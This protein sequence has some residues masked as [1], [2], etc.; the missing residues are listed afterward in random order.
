MKIL[1]IGYG[2]V[3]SVLV[4]LLM[5]EKGVEKIYCLDLK[6]F[7]K[8]K[9]SKVHF[10]VFNA[11]DKIKFIGYLNRVRPDVVINAA[12]PKFNL[13]IMESCLEANV[14]YMDAAS[15][16]DLDK[17]P[18]AKV[19]YKME[20]LDYHK[21]FKDNKILGLIE[22]GVAPGLDNMFAAQA[23]SELDETDY[24]KIR[25]VEDT[26]SKEIFFSWN[27]DWLLDEIGSKPIIYDKG[28]W[29]FVE[30]F[31]AEEEFEFPKPIGK[32]KTYY[33]CQD[34]VGSIP[35]YV[36]TKKLDVKIHDN[37]IEISKLLLAL[38]LV[39]SKPI[40]VDGVEVKPIRVLSKLLPDPV[41]GEE[42]KFPNSIFAFAVEAIGKKDGKKKAV[43]YSIVFPNQREI[44]KMNIG[45]NFISY[46]TA[47]SMKLFTMALDR[48]TERGVYPPEILNKKIREDIIKQLPKNHVKVYK[49][50]Y[51]PK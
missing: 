9:N 14:N 6:F 48:V 11:L 47:L 15:Y 10:E 17:D 22:A 34:E 23:A 31:G 28:K 24:I 19:P 32:R 1:I 21:Q 8:L 16:W 42:K 37:N 5:K 3:G 7:E 44:G 33:F 50:V 49:K 25:M 20:Q 18:N 4:K 29:S 41:P 45:A 35:D 26:G 12:I 13:N 40:N 39:S 2:A 30:S 38:G 36:K 51:T 43:R 46:P 27:K